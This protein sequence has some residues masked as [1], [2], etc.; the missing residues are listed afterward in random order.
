MSNC[1]DL[2]IGVLNSTDRSPNCS[3]SRSR[4]VVANGFSEYLYPRGPKSVI[5]EGAA[6]AGIPRWIQDKLNVPLINS[7]AIAVAAVEMLA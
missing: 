3:E 6:V 7:V 2:L 1:R 5:V 4:S